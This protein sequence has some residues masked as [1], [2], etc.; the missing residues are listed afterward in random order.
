[1][2]TFE[3]KRDSWHYKA[4]DFGSSFGVPRETDICRYFWLVLRGVLLFTFAATVLVGIGG[5]LGFS[6][7]NGLMSLFFGWELLP[8]SV[9]GLS[10]ISGF[11]A[12]IGYVVCYRYFKDKIRSIENKPVEESGFVTLAYRKFKDKTC[13]RIILK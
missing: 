13:A 7:A 1:M 4:A 10:I 12:V 3:L 8:I 6:I 2:K 9:I 5:V 11:F